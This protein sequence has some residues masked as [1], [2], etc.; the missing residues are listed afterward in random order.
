MSFTFDFDLTNGVL[1]CRPHGPVNDEVLRDFFRLGAKYALRTRP[2]AGIVDLSEVTSFEVSTETIRELAVSDPVLPDPGPLR[3]VVAP[4]AH[5]FGMMRMFA[6]HG[7]QARPNLHVVHA[8]KE[9]W[10]ILAVTDPQF[11]PLDATNHT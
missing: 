3:I 6:A 9:A 2:A 10:A 4:T 5:L 7:E 8:E 11:E 1:R